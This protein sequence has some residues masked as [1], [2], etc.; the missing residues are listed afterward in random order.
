MAESVRLMP[1]AVMADLSLR[2]NSSPSSFSPSQYVKPAAPEKHTK[3]LIRCVGRLRIFA[4]LV[5]PSWRSLNQANTFVYDHSLDVIYVWCGAK[6]NRSEQVK[7]MS[8]ATVI[9]DHERSAKAKIVRIEPTSSE[10]EKREFWQAIANGEGDMSREVPPGDEGF[11][12]QATNAFNNQ[13]QLYQLTLE[14]PTKIPHPRGLLMAMLNSSNSYALDTGDEFYLWFG[15]QSAI[16]IEA[17]QR[18]SRQIFEATARPSWVE[19][20]R[21]SEGGEPVLFRE[22]FSDWPDLSHSEVLKRKALRSPQRVTLPPASSQRFR[23]S[24]L[25]VESQDRE[26]FFPNEADSLALDSPQIL[27]VWRVLEKGQKVEVTA[28]E[29]GFFPLDS[30]FIVVAKYLSS[31]ADRFLVILWKGSNS[32]RLLSGSGSILLTSIY[33]DLRKDQF[34]DQMVL[35]NNDFHLHFASLFQSRYFV[36][37]SPWKGPGTPSCRL[38]H[39]RCHPNHLRF[40]PELIS[41]STYAVETALTAASLNTNDAFILWQAEGNKASVWIGNHCHPTVR[42]IAVQMAARL[43]PS[44]PLTFQESS[45][46]VSFWQPLGG[47][48]LYKATE[49]AMSPPLFFSFDAHTSSFRPHLVPNFSQNDLDAEKI[50]LLHSGN[51]FYLWSSS[52]IPQTDRDTANE[53]TVEY[54]QAWSEHNSGQTPTITWVVAWEEPPAFIRLFHAW[55]PTARPVTKQQPSFSVP[56]SAVRL[57]GLAGAVPVLPP[58]SSPSSPSTSKFPFTS[59][60]SSSS[61]SSPSVSSSSPIRSG[62]AV[63]AF[64]QVSLRPTG[65]PKT[66]VQSSPTSTPTVS[67]S[68]PSP[69]LR[70]PALSPRATTVPPSPTPPSGPQPVFPYSVLSTNPPDHLD[71]SHLEIYLSDEE[72][73]FIFH[74]TKATFQ[75]WPEWKRTL[76]RK[77]AKLF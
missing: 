3:R 56:R 31:M 8:L 51:N 39:V 4:V 38:F 14:A 49:A 77:E 68:S 73:N 65:S 55:N 25:W 16:P 58:L 20:T 27:N 76:K 28:A 15:A 12:Q 1:Q 6:S 62:S 35:S 17:A 44:A 59:K 19:M 48:L 37:S 52:L 13:F 10:A 18:A 43:T 2:L 66:T 36:L 26:N 24:Q 61:P 60:A 34:V 70:S 67:P 63:P 75:S 7:G 64:A 33:N 57:P 40:A 23:G 41:L 22:K 54:A 46:P 32:G 42:E 11:A 29:Q 72:F 45:A 69:Q 47:Q 53:I 74:C 30:A 50:A 21:V 9:K 71:R 5:E